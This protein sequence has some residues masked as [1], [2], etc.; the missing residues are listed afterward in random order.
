MAVVLMLGSGPLAALMALER[1]ELGRGRASSCELAAPI[2][3]PAR[4]SAPPAGEGSL[5]ASRNAESCAASAFGA[6][7]SHSQTVSTDQPSASSAATVAPS[8]TR[9][10]PILA[11]Q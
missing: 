6:R 4:G 1:N 11:R 5:H 3:S 7:V 10:R 9:L 8:R 2:P